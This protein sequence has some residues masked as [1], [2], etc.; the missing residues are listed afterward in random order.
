MT[1]N[2]PNGLKYKIR[3]INKSW[4][5]SPTGIIGKVK[6]ICLVCGKEFEVMPC[7]KDT[8]EYCS[9]ICLGKSK[10]NKKPARP[11]QKGHIPWNRGKK[12]PGLSEMRIGK[13]NPM[14]G[15]PSWNKG[16]PMSEK[17]KRKLNEFH[18]KHSTKNNTKEQL[19]EFLCQQ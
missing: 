13:K 6:K 16:K 11:F 7:R 9:R 19:E 10:R 17:S 3:Q 8:A 12:L 15:R 4:F 1:K 18:K 5:K 14:F 2:R